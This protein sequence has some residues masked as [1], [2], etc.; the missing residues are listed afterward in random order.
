MTKNILKKVLIGLLAGFISGFF[1]TGGGLI[2]VPSFL[3]LLNLESQKA[4]GTSI[5]CILP[6]VITSSF[7]YYKGN[8]INLKN[9]HIMWY[10]RINRWMYR[11][12]VI[13]KITRK[14]IKNIIYNIFNL[15][16]F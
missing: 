13:K 16:I 14:N 6:M 7:I 12:K 1:S 10:R 2:L 8:F 15:Y 11:R 5:F 3:Y 4:R 9:I